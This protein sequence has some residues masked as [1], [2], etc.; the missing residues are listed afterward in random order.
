MAEWRCG[1]CTYMNR[2]NDSSVCSMC[3][4]T[5]PSGSVGAPRADG[6]ADLGANSPA[7]AGSFGGSVPSFLSH[8]SRQLSGGDVTGSGAPGGAGGGVRRASGGFLNLD[9]LGELAGRGGTPGT[10]P[11]QAPG[12]APAAPN[13]SGGNRAEGGGDGPDGD[14]GAGGGAAGGSAGDAPPAGRQAPAAAAPAAAPAAG[15]EGGAAPGVVISDE[16]RQFLMSSR[17]YLPFVIL[18]LMLFVHQHLLGLATFAVMTVCLLQLSIRF[19]QQVALKENLQRRVMAMVFFLSVTNGLSIY[20]F[21]AEEELWRYLMFQLPVRAEALPGHTLPLSL[22]EVLWVISMND[23]VI[24]FAGL[25][26]N[27]LVAAMPCSCSMRRIH[28]SSALHRRKR[29]IFGLVD[30]G[31]A[32]LRSIY[33]TPVWMRFFAEQSSS[34]V[35]ANGL[36][37]AYFT[38]KLLTLFSRGL[39][40]WKQ[41]QAF[42]TASV[43]FGRASTQAE[44]TEAGSPDCSIC[45]DPLTGPITLPCS[46]MYCEACISEWLE[47]EQTCPICRATVPSAGRLSHAEASNSLITALF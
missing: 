24:R 30:L 13:G 31:L 22:W 32:L 40:F 11:A 39:E 21:F 43:P 35:V 25:A 38:I 42:V 3:G 46:H 8:L 17:N 23:M 26:I 29:H 34:E 12:V 45:Q 16:A 18:L 2:D 14:A 1:A 44:I 6:S 4:T 20:L 10:A 33:S 41:L 37:G 27:A 15:A 28:S 9:D 47:R 19:R 5:R 7:T 36:A